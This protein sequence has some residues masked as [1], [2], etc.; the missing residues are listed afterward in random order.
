MPAMPRPRAR[1]AIAGLAVATVTSIP[2]L[3]AGAHSD[4]LAPEPPPPVE[5]VATVPSPPPPVTARGASP[6]GV[7]EPAVF[8]GHVLSTGTGAP[9]PGAELTFSR[10]E[11]AEVVRAGPD[12]AFRFNARI[13][14][15]WLLAAVWAPGYFPF[16]PEWGYSQLQF[17]AFPGEQVRGVDV[18]LSPALELEGSVVDEDGS[19]VAGAVVS[20]LGG[21]GRALILI[22]DRFLAD[23]AGRFRVAAPLDS[24]LE[25]EAP[26]YYT[27]HAVVDLPTIANGKFEIAL[28]SAWAGRT[29]ARAALRGRVVTEDR[30]PVPAALVEARQAQG[31]PSGGATVAQALT[32]AE[33][34]FQFADL[35][36]SPLELSARAEGY[37][38]GLVARAV[39]GGPMTQIVLSAGARLRGCVKDGDTG[40]SVAPF[41]I[42]A[43]DAQNRLRSVPD[44]QASVADPSGCFTLDGLRPGTV[45]LMVL[46]PRH[47][48][49][50]VAEVEIPEP[51][52]QGEVQITLAAGGVITGTVRDEQTGAPIP[53]ARVTAE[54]ITQ[55]DDGRAPASV[56][57]AEAI[58]GA[59]GSFVVNAL[60][61]AVRLH[62]YAAGHHP[63]ASEPVNV[64]TGGVLWPVIIDLPPVQE[65]RAGPVLPV[66]IGAVL[67]PEGDAIAIG[68]LRP[69]STAEASGLEPGDQLLQIDERP[70]ADLGLGGAVEA[71][72]GP[73]GTPVLL[74]VRRDASEFQVAV[75]R[76]R[77]N[78]S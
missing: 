42:L 36:P 32:D 10:G 33:G 20:L 43:Y 77:K 12:G 72:R 60:P 16:A 28:G 44:E 74:L 22:P 19:P 73:E 53:D 30:R 21:G 31:W 66:G 76:Q 58:T 14:G 65:G 67:I 34:R 2:L 38:P 4:E 56:T 69:G 55:L 11:A 59:D 51:P 41:T 78:R 75:Q 45:D 50:Q 17:D 47:A 3:L 46:A 29:P 70:V 18:F 8:E 23:E 15:Q 54:P 37:T 1:L 25:A 5:A 26:G 7:L 24:V 64:P 57:V 48:P 52:A 9:V 27:G 62:A 68:A 35:D 6:E 40:E 61:S 71:L 49:T 63:A 13:P 39:P